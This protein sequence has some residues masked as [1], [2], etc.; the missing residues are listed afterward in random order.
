MA[1]AKN[2]TVA[3]GISVI[4][5]SLTT[6]RLPSRHAILVAKSTN[7]KDFPHFICTCR[8]KAVPLQPFLKNEP[9]WL[10][11]TQTTNGIQNATYYMLDGTEIP[12]FTRCYDSRESLLPMY[13]YVDLNTLLIPD[14][15]SP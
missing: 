5:F 12:Q 15:I 13:G 1:V 2:A 8:K 3:Y 4:K 14:A 10:T 6:A 7:P 9:H 11:K